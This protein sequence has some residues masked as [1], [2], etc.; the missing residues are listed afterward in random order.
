MKQKKGGP[1]QVT[2]TIL[3]ALALSHHVSCAMLLQMAALP[4]LVYMYCLQ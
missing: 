1:V 4:A 2:M 3:V